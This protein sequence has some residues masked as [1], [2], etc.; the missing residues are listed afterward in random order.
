MPTFG[1]VITPR[2]FGDALALLAQ[3]P[4]LTLGQGGTRVPAVLELD[5]DD[6]GANALDALRDHPAVAAVDIA[7][8]DFS[9]LKEP[10]DSG[11]FAR[12][13]RR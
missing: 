5:S 4:G 8:A 10:I 3:V 1:L 13:R 11:V 2:P 7:F 9:D 12:R 6:P